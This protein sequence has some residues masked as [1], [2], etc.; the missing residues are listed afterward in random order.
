MV[1]PSAINKHPDADWADLLKAAIPQVWSDGWRE[2]D[3]PIRVDGV[4]KENKRGPC[5]GYH[6]KLGHEVEIE[7]Y[8]L[9]WTTWTLENQE[10]KVNTMYD[11]AIVGEWLEL[12]SGWV[13]FFES[14]EDNYGNLGHQILTELAQSLEPRGIPLPLAL[15]VVDA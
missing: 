13:N 9:T 4:P 6:Y 2:A 10:I 11:F 1:H 5:S 15:E 3:V 14:T 8:R 12:Q 7:K